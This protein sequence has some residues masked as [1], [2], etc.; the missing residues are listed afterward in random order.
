MLIVHVTFDIKPEYVDAFQ[1]ASLINAENSLKESGVANFEL[2]HSMEETTRFMLIEQY[3]TK[4]DQLAHRETSH[5]KTWK[6][7]ITEM[8]QKP[9]T[10]SKWDK[11]TRDC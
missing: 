7:T 1:E 10:F 11:I 5:F 4:E 3:Y 6:E 9:Y 8:L 2:L